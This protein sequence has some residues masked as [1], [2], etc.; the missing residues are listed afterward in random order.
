MSGVL[1]GSL[2]PEL[3][4][5]YGLII[6]FIILII[7]II[8]IDKKE[9]TKQQKNL[10]DTLNMKIIEDNQKNQE[11]ET[12]EVKEPEIK[13]EMTFSD[14]ERVPN[15]DILDSEEELKKTIDELNN[16]EYVE[17]DLEK[18]QA[19][20]RIEEITKA[21]AAANIDEKIEKDKYEIFEEEQE[22]NA[23]ISYNELKESFDKLYSENEKI[24]YQEDDSIPIN[25]QELYNLNKEITEEPTKVKLDDFDM[26]KKQEPASTSQS[27]FKSSPY[28]SPVY[29]IQKPTVEV[30]KAIDNDIKD[31]SDFLNSLKDLKNNLE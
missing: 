20:I 17:T 18:T 23:I 7:A 29:G 13:E 26:K 25:I 6:I 27:T 10:F 9:K 3:L 12:I 30:V 4:L 22:K 24:Q 2:G 11:L 1:N 15:I 19:Q 28:I 5:V 8:I 31:T 14:I 16:E 21:L